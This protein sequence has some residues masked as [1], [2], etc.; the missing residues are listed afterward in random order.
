M[1]IKKSLS[2]SVYS[3]LFSFSP[4]QTIPIH[5]SDELIFSATFNFAESMKLFNRSSL[6][7]FSF[8]FNTGNLSIVLLLNPL[9]F[10]TAIFPFSFS[11]IKPFV[12]RNL[13]RQVSRTLFRINCKSILEFIILLKSTRAVKFL[14]NF[15][16]S[17]RINLLMHL[18]F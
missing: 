12:E 4:R 1:V 7:Q 18:Y 9:E 16:L 2:L 11:A 8:V 5:S 3:D 14:F 17:S 15:K 6:R 10:F 13:P